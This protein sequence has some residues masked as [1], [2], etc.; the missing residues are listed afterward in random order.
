M[1][2]SSA[3]TATLLLTATFASVDLTG[4]E[5]TTS[6]HRKR[7]AHAVPHKSNSQRLR[8]EPEI[9]E[10][11]LGLVPAHPRRLAAPHSMSMSMPMTGGG[12]MLGGG[13]GML[14]GGGFGFGGGIGMG[15]PA[16]SF[17]GQEGATLESRRD[18]D[19][20]EYTLCKFG[21][22]TAC[23]S[24][25]YARGECIESN[26]I[27]SVY[28]A[29]NEGALST[30]SVDWGDVQGR[31]AASYET[32]TEQ[33]RGT[34]TEGDYYSSR[35]CYPTEVPS[36]SAID[37]TEAPTASPIDATEAPMASPIDLSTSDTTTEATRDAIF[38]TDPDPGLEERS[39]SASAL[40]ATCSLMVLA[41]AHAVISIVGL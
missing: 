9:V 40:P 7:A 2:V 21:E 3:A 33:D 37:A 13:G 20:G 18:T 27:F 17:C 26:P 19:G 31:P 36:A 10:A 24:W 41:G 5:A 4:A 22:D 38:D 30:E 35:G 1:R 16:D 11:Y 14:G 15:N 23:D 39:V 12:G 29:N 25:A 32:C 34:C 8:K 28:C 6:P